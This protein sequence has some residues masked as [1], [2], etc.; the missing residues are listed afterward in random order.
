MVDPQ[1]P[2][3]PPH[4]RELDPAMNPGLQSAQQQALSGACRF[5][6][7][8]LP[9]P[10]PAEPMGTFMAWMQLAAEKRVQPNPNA[11]TLSTVGADGWPSSRIV[12]ARSVDVQRGYVVFFTNYD[13][14]KGREIASGNRVALCFHWDHL[15]RQVRIEGVATPCPAME[16]DAYFR[17][18][19]LLSRVAAWASDQSQPIASRA[20]L[21]AKNDE[22]ER[23]FG[24]I[25]GRA[26]NPGAHV[27]RP[28]H[29]GGYRVWARSVELWLGNTHRLHDRARWQRSLTPAQ[30]DDAPGFVGAA[31][32]SARLQ[33]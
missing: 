7:E 4:A 32:T 24:I 23:R 8:L 2:H 20:D 6:D 5:S 1:H 33:P 27:P 31:W 10:L 13:S 26:T 17:S 28:A 19:P 11:M 14:R 3:L 25:D 30:I 9:D 22:A 29:W 16:S 15:D 18:R 21:L 12:L